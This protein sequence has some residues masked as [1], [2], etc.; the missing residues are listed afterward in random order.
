MSPNEGVYGCLIEYNTAGS[1]GGGVA[2]GGPIVNCIIRGNASGDVGAG[3]YSPRSLVSG[4]IV[5]ENEGMGIYARDRVDYLNNIIANNEGGGLLPARNS[6]VRNNSIYG[7]GD[8]GLFRNINNTVTNN[9]IWGNATQ[10]SNI[11]ASGMVITYNCIEGW[12][13][14]GTG[15]ITLNPMFANPANG[16]FS[17]LPGSPCIDAGAPGL[18]D[19]CMPPGQGAARADMGALG[20]TEN[21]AHIGSGAY[22]LARTVIGAVS[23]NPLGLEYGDLNDDEKINALDVILALRLKDFDNIPGWE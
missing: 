3:I 7:N 10:L 14:G 2:Y 13:E 15:N 4:C 1:N 17:L 18:S 19:A 20:G 5:M 23:A 22:S 12:T 8:W 21:C 16:D 9:I 11:P 6:I